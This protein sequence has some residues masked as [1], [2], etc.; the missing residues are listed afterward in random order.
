MLAKHSLDCDL[1]GHLDATL[2]GL[3]EDA[4]NALDIEVITTR[5][6]LVLTFRISLDIPVIDESFGFQFKTGLRL[7][8][9]VGELDV[10]EVQLAA[11][12]VWHV[13]DDLASCDPV[14]LA[15]DVKSLV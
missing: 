5:L 11:H 3:F 15:D 13:A 2:V 1:T 8:R 4:L 7:G 9:V 14:V 12:H 6:N 10:F